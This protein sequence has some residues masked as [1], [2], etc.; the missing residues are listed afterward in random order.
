[1]PGARESMWAD[2]R[3]RFYD[4]IPSGDQHFAVRTCDGAGRVVRYTKHLIRREASTGRWLWEGAH[5]T[6][7][8]GARGES[9]VWRCRAGGR[10]FTWTPTLPI[11]KG[12]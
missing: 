8:L 7:E 2:G 10:S 3:G 5:R 1:M 4:V 12:L 6:F 11:N 9:L